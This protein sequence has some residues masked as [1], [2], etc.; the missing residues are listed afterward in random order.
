MNAN[1][2][3]CHSAPEEAMTQKSAGYSTMERKWAARDRL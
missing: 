2:R 3:V 1:W